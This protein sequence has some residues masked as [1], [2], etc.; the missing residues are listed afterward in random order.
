MLS[1]VHHASVISP[2]LQL[3]RVFKGLTPA[4][5]PM[6]LQDCRESQRLNQVLYPTAGQAHPHA[7]S[8]VHHAPVI[9]PFLQLH[10]GF[11]GL[12][13]AHPPMWLQDC[14][15][16]QRLN[17]VLY[18]TAG[19]AHPHALSVVHHAPV[20]FPFLQLHRGFQGLTPAHPPMWLQDCRESQGLNQVPY[21]TSLEVSQE[22]HDALLPGPHCQV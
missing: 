7:L 14:R 17:Q 11:Q 19:Q 21:P 12:T 10:R 20:I 8:V 22:F 4:H 5:P 16:S 2:F 13:P 15:E 6:W 18:P 1:A 3:H 9:F